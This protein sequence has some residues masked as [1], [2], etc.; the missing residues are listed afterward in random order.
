M[1]EIITADRPGKLTFDASWT[2]PHPGAVITTENG[3]L[4]L[5]GQGGDYNDQAPF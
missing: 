5:S 1:V 3:L 2:T 4:T